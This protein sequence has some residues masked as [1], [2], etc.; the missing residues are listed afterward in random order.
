MEKAVILGTLAYSF[1]R[2]ILNRFKR[3][4]GVT[5]ADF[6]FGPYDFY[7]MVQSE[8]K[9]TL[10]ETAVRIRFIKGVTSTTTCHVVDVTDIRPELEEEASLEYSHS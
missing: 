2:E 1:P 3:M 7:V 9:E 8:T 5:D 10:T 4:Q 6:I